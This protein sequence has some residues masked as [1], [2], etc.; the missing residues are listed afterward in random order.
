MNPIQPLCR[1]PAYYL[2]HPTVLTPDLP[3]SI[4]NGTVFSDSTVDALDAEMSQMT[5]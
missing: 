2:A 1:L 5:L 3:R 4:P